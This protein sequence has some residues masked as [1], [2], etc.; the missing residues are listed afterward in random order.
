MSS[1]KPAW[2]RRI[3]RVSVYQRGERYWIYYR[4]GKQ[5]RYPVGTDREEALALGAKV[6]AQLA[7]GAPTLLSFHPI[8]LDVLIRKWIDHHEQIRRSSL[9]TAQRYRTAVAHLARYVESTRGK[10]R[11][12][13]LDASMAEGLVRYLRTTPVS[14]NGHKNTEKRTMRD[15][16]VV[17]VLESCRALFNFARDQ[18]HLPAYSPNPFAGLAIDR[19]RIE[20]AKP[21][22]PLTAEQEI[23]FFK[24]CDEWQFQVF[25][26][27]AFTGLRVGELTH[28]LI[29]N[30]VRLEENLIR[31]TNKPGLFWQVKT[32]NLRDVPI[33][34]EVAQVLR[35]CIQ[36]RQSGPVV[37]RRR[38][39]EGPL[40]PPLAGRSMVD[41]E[42]EVRS[43]VQAAKAEQIA[44]LTRMQTTRAGRSVWRDAGAVKETTIRVEFMSITKRIGL[45]HL[46][47][48]KDLRHL[49]ATSLQAAGVDPMIRRDIMG[50]TTLD[51]TAH[52]THTQ[53]GTR[54]RELTRLAE[55]RGNVLQLAHERC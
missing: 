6:N 39:T 35:A 18:R 19:M 4:Q 13:R 43:R 22:R 12:D 8:D 52:Y 5:F 49:F 16:G 25:F 45:E 51:M 46:T 1:S 41:L 37:L 40:A 23:E 50:H 26:L 33:L 9:A 54:Q 42:V 21:I 30:D 20:D 17:F 48:P 55:V 7:E 38:F 32:R 28:L 53:N 15:K 44:V 47:C 27:L 29:D 31:V 24:A 14:P 36:D 34:P 11:A 3:G 2:R 10:L